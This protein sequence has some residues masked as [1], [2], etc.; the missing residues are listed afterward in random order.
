LED[1]NEIGKLRRA[2]EDVQK[3]LRLLR[4]V[5]E[6]MLTGQQATEYRMRVDRNPDLV[7]YVESLGDRTVPSP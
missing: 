6:S 1:D 4:K 7:E 5:G 3:E 2:V